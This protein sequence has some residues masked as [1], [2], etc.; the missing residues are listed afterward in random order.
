MLI[1]NNTRLILG[2]W[3]LAPASIIERLRLQSAEKNSLVQL[4]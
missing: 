1:N 3:S 4:G 2:I